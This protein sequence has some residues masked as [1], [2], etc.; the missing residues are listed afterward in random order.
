MKTSPWQSAFII[1]LLIGISLGV[2]QTIGA[3]H[4]P[5]PPE[6]EETPTTPEGSIQEA[7]ATFYLSSQAKSI[8][9]RDADGSTL[10]ES[11]ETDSAT[12][13][14][15]NFKLP[16][17]PHEKTGKPESTLLIDIEFVNPGERN[18]AHLELKMADYDKKT[19]PLHSI[20]SIFEEV[21]IKW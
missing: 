4:S 3:N 5:T 13:H 8:V 2:W 18:F 6:A 7:K 17:T 19:I 12:E 20:S 9:I 14:E 1:I 15:C 16:V 21:R 11:S 10:Y